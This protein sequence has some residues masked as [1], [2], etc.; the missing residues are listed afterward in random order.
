[1][2]DLRRVVEPESNENL[3]VVVLFVDR[4][5]W[6]ALLMMANLSGRGGKVCG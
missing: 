4:W 6:Y 1:V 3:S 2:R 5:V